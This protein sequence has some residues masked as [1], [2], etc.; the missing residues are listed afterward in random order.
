MKTKAKSRT[1][2]FNGI[3][4]ATSSVI[5]GVAFFSDFLKELLPSLGYIGL[6]LIIAANNAV[7]WY[8]RT[9]TTEAIS[10]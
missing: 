8:L 5:A 6:L 4:G 3:M 2:W 7:G 9:T 1:L 10:K